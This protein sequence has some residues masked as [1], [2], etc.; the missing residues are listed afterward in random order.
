MRFEDTQELF[1]EE[2][3]AKYHKM[4]L[5]R[6]MRY[7]NY[8]RRCMDIAQSCVQDVLMTAFQK[9]AELNDHPNIAGWLSR[10]CD[11]RMPEY[12]KDARN[13]WNYEISL[14]RLTERGLAVGQEEPIQCWHETEANQS[15]VNEMMDELSDS[16]KALLSARYI[17]DG[18]MDEI[19]KKRGTTVSTVKVQL[20]RARKKAEKIIRKKKD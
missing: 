15:T 2:L 8:D 4:M 6:C 13:I 16:D 20:H 9:Y 18:T 3:E 1:V 14:D 7:V 19:A 17:E 11:F 12:A 10:A 5:N